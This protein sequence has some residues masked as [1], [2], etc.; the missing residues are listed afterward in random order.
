MIIPERLMVGVSNE[1]A[2][3][4]KQ[5]SQGHGLK[6]SACPGDVVVNSENNLE[7]L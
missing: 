3:S 2:S 4:F 1:T 5:A 6:V 7:V